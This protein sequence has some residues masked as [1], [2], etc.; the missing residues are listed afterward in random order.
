MGRR[1]LLQGTVPTKGLALASPA[2]AGSFFTMVPP[3]K[4]APPRGPHGQT[5]LTAKLESPTF[6]TTD[7]LGQIILLCGTAL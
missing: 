3:G 4:E 7:V 1:F 2:L 6:S 5:P